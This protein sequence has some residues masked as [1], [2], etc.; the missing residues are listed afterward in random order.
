M[1]KTVSGFTSVWAGILIDTI[2]V[3]GVSNE[4]ANLISFK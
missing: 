3:I 4:G 2:R 1:D